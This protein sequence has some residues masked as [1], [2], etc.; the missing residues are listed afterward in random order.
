MTSLRF[1]RAGFVAALFATG[2][3]LP[4]QDPVMRNADRIRIAESFRLARAIG[5]EL[6]PGA[7]TTPFP[8]LLIAR[9]TE[10]LIGHPRPSADF[11]PLGYD[12]LLQAPT[13]WRPRV[14]PVDRLATFPAVGGISTIVVGLPEQTKKSS[15]FWVLTIL[16][17]RFHQLQTSQAGY[18]DGVAKLDLA[19]GDQTGMWMLNYPFPYD[20][21]GV[22]T[23]FHEYRDAVRRGLA[24][25]RDSEADSV[26]RSLL[27]SR[28]ALRSVLSPSDWRYLEFQL[29]Q[30]GVSRYTE[31]RVAQAAASQTPLA[32]YAKL[33]DVISYS[34]AADSLR[35][36]LERELS[37]LNLT[38][39]KRVAFYPTGAG[40]ALLLDRVSPDWRRRYFAEPFALEPLYRRPR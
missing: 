5:D 18:Y 40:E 26:M 16:H 15:T 39:W 11:K 7:A 32:A 29:W 8:V 36:H 22:V 6:G 31:L 30:E 34:A 24:V 17:E 35:N 12:S 21:S 14:F 33:P 27:A 25:R 10:F 19:H 23:R 1:A 37:S 38:G 20:S 2:T 28:A 4:A 9:E 13:F 3:E